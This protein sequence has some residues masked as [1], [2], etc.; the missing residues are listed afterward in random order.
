VERIANGIDVARYASRDAGEREEY[1]IGYAGRLVAGK[2]L[3][4]LLR[5]FAL[6]LEQVPHARLRIA[7]D[8]PER[9][10]IAGRARELGVSDRVSVM[11][12]VH[13]MP[14]FWRC[15]SVGVMPSTARESFGMAALEA[16]AAGRP[17]VAS[18]TGGIRE[19][20]E[21]GETGTLVA[22]GDVQ[23]LAGALLGYATQPDLRR[24]H[25]SAGRER[26]ES[27]FT[28]S[29]CAARYAELLA[30]LAPARVENA[31][32]RAA[33]AIAGVGSV[34]VGGSGGSLE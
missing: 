25:G 5:A 30:E 16:M 24:Q 4:Q 10:A 13:D 20:V 6:V 23:E 8:G 22:P 18:R 17:V 28:M 14:S 21:D 33:H 34:E 19:L 11:G 31:Q 26:C 27:Q 12:V 32:P 7:G 2:G 9:A 1:V 29:R 3:G 15:T